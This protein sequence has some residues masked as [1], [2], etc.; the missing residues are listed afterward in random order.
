MS[1]S[2]NEILQM[3]SSSNGTSW[4]YRS[5][6]SVKPWVQSPLDACV[7][8]QL[9]EKI[10]ISN[11]KSQWNQTFLHHKHDIQNSSAITLYWFWEGAL[12]VP[13]DVQFTFISSLLTSSTSPSIQAA[14]GSSTQTWDPIDKLDWATWLV[15]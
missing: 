7:K 3:S 1:S 8:Y 6:W 9:K 10:L 2:S 4:S 13:P 14:S 11:N 15:K 5:K 12:T